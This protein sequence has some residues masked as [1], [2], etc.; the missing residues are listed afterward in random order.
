VEVFEKSPFEVFCAFAGCALPG[1]AVFGQSCRRREL[2][3]G[4]PLFL[5]GEAQPYV[6]TVVRGVIKLV[7]ETAN[8]DTWVKG[9]AEPGMCFAS[10][11]ALTR[12]GLT[13]YSAYAAT[14]CVAC[15]IDFSTLERLA[16]IHLE[17]QRAISNAFKFYGQ[18]KEQREKELLTLS[19]EERYRAFLRD[20]PQLPPLLRQHDIAGYIRVTPVALSRIKSRLKARDRVK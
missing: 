12:N 17:W 6:F 11:T 4:Q 9:F 5:T 8:G 16:G 14:C 19:A 1:Q 18:R 2:A 3:A 15:Q 7:Y 20:H 10:L 13:S